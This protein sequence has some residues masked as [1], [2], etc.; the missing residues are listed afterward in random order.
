[1]S[2]EDRKRDEPLDPHDP[3]LF[4]K[5]AKRS[6]LSRTRTDK[7]ADELTRAADR[8]RPK[9][10]WGRAGETNLNIRVDSSDLANMHPEQIRAFFEGLIVALDRIENARSRKSED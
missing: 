1:M 5:V 7:L 4:E 2:D 8:N 9:Q 3:D 10:T 6:R